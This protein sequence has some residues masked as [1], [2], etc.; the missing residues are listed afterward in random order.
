MPDSPQ[1]AARLVSTANGFD[2]IAV[3]GGDGTARVVA[4]ALAGTAT[5]LAVIP[6]GSAN[7][8]AGELGV[9][10][11]PDALARMITFGPARPI[12]LGFANAEPFVV[13][14]GAGLDGDAAR[15]VSAG[16]KRALGFSA[17]AAAIAGASV[18]LS[19]VRLSVEADGA[20]HEAAWAMA[21]NARLAPGRIFEACG[22]MRLVLVPPGPIGRGAALAGLAAG[23]LAQAPGLRIITFRRARITSTTPVP[24]QIDGEA[25]GR[26]PLDI[27][28]A[29][30]PIFALTPAAA[31]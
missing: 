17:Y 24:T 23:R 14:A 3:A 10:A 27:A 31:G 8:L 2:A 26:T 12:A 29:P 15:R 18:D 20:M 5:P 4:G 16:L 7:I 28:I 6:A 30:K 25:L 13:M 9:C 22:V 19:R 21:L 1:A 11:N